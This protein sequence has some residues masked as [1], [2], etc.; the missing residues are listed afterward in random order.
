MG[1]MCDIICT[2]VAHVSYVGGLGMSGRVKVFAPIAVVL[3]VVLAAVVWLVA[4][5]RGGGPAGGPEGQASGSAV[6]VEVGHQP[7]DA[8]HDQLMADWVTADQALGVCARTARTLD[9]LNTTG[10][11]QV[12]AQAL[13]LTAD[14]QGAERERYRVYRETL[15]RFSDGMARLGACGADRACAD[16]AYT[17]TGVAWWQAD[18]QFDRLVD[19]AR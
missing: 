10:A 5:H 17:D 8:V 19:P 13:W 6:G 7:A 18:I 12:A 16:R 11:G 9:C 2:S 1:L 14:K 15:T 4:G 3:V